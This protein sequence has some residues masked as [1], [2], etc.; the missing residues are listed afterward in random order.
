[1]ITIY[2]TSTGFQ[3][4]HQHIIVTIQGT[5]PSELE[6]ADIQID[7]ETKDISE[8]VTDW[9]GSLTVWGNP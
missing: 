4:G 3:S 6:M 2:S 1:M 7:Y 8:H 9:K 5:T